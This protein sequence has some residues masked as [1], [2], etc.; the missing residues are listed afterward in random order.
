MQ[1]L[2]ETTIVEGT[3]KH[4]QRHVY[5]YASIFCNALSFRSTYIGSRNQHN[6]FENLIHSG[7]C[8][9]KWQEATQFKMF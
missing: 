4:S 3:K 2:I 7:K 8:P 9:C 1:F 5:T 6:Y